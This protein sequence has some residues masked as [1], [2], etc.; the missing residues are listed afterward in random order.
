LCFQLFHLLKML[1]FSAIAG[2]MMI[3]TMLGSIA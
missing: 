3:P 2:M 1:V